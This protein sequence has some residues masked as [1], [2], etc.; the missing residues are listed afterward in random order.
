MTRLLIVD[1]YDSSQVSVDEDPKDDDAYAGL[2]EAYVEARV[3]GFQASQTELSGEARAAAQRAIALDGRSADGYLALA[4]N[5]MDDWQFGAAG[6]EYR[7][8][9][10]LNPN[11]ATAHEGYAVFLNFTGRFNEAFEQDQRALEL[12]PTGSLANAWLGMIYYFQR[13]YGRS[14]AQNQQTLE[15]NPELCRSVSHHD[16]LL[17]GRTR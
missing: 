7:R 14:I 2:A 5:D 8:S 11:L 12:D 9:V 16:Q 13:D 17:L 6:T 15:I 3:M 1:R 10:D 4:Q